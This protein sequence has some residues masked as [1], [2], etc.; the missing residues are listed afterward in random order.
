[1]QTSTLVFEGVEAFKGTYFR[2]RDRAMLDAYDRVVDSGST[3]WLQTIVANLQRNGE[4]W[5]GLTHFMIT[6]DDGPTYEFIARG[7]RI[8]DH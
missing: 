2:A 7:F 5:Q 8:D 4:S 6:F 1:V 3:P